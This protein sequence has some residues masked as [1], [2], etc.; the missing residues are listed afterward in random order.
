MGPEFSGGLNHEALALPCPQRHSESHL[1]PVSRFQRGAGARFSAPITHLLIPAGSTPFPL[2]SPPPVLVL[3]TIGSCR[4]S[5]G[6]EGQ[7]SY[8]VECHLRSTEV[9]PFVGGMPYHA[10]FGLMGRDRAW[11]S[12]TG[13]RVARGVEGAEF[14]RGGGP[15]RKHLPRALVPWQG[16]ATEALPLVGGMP[17]HKGVGPWAVP[18]HACST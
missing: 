7:A 1:E 13:L 12:P 15:P 14:F 2:D 9:L 5:G 4:L 6:L 11:Q 10:G 16:S 17:D 18:D 8:G 3:E